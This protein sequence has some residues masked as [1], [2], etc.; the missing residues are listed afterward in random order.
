MN[1]IELLRVVDFITHTR[2]PFV[3][4]VAGAEVDA[5]WTITSHLIRAGLLQEPLSITQLIQVSGLP[6]G[7]AT[8][9]IQRLIESGLINK[10]AA[11]ELGKSY[12][13]QASSV[14]RESFI[15]Y[16]QRIKALLAEAMGQRLDTGRL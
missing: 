8:R 16:A 1:D 13:L 3:E 9:R 11:G 15:Q 12:L 10:V 14:L 7:T 2:Q 4:L 6:Y 5:S